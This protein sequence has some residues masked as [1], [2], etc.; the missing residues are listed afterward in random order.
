M[1]S[2]SS[3]RKWINVRCKMRGSIPLTCWA[4]LSINTGSSEISPNFELL[5]RRTTAGSSNFLPITKWL[6]RL[7]PACR[8]RDLSQS[9]RSPT[10]SGNPHYS[11]RRCTEV[12]SGRIY[13]C[14]FRHLLTAELQSL[15]KWYFVY[16]EVKSFHF[17]DTCVLDR[18]V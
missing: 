17:N 16:L 9:L 18:L 13:W 2:F 4:W 1:R 7:V 10:G 15:R 14:L 12:M 8:N 5:I 3:Q 11:W 6:P